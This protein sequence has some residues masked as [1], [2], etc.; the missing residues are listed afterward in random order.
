MPNL[1]D[2][3]HTPDI[4]AAYNFLAFE[5]RQIIRSRIHSARACLSFGRK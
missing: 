4:I 1:L 5:V 3:G 2:G